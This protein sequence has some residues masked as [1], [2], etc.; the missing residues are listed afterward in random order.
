MVKNPAEAF[1]TMLKKIT[2]IILTAIMIC[3]CLPVAASAKN[4]PLT[5]TLNIAAINQNTKGSGYEWNNIDSVLTLSDCEINT[6][7]EYGLKLPAN[8]VVELNG[9]NVI[10]AS[11]VGIHCLSSV[12]FSGSGSLTIIAESIGITCAS[13][14]EK[15]TVRFRS[16]TITITSEGY[17]IYSEN[18]T[19]SFTGAEVNVSAKTNSL[20]GNNMQFVSGKINLNPSVKAKGKVEFSGANVEITSDTSAVNA[21]RG[22]TFSGCN[23][24]VG[25]NADSL[26]EADVYNGENCLKLVSTV[27]EV[28]TSKIFGE[29]VPAFVDYII[30]VLIILMIAAVIFVPIYIKAQKTKKLTEMSKAKK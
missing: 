3:C 21:T 11:S 6:S 12:T 28:H 15:D 4:T 9:K 7:D 24:S 1:Q 20:S 10:K 27:K 17:G 26:T 22:I 13:T 14:S 2:T 18:A 5:S 25:S 8:S 23:I 16:G 29:N 19:L 30:F